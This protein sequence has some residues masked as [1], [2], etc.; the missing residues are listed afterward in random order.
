MHVTITG[1]GGFI[2]RRL[3]RQLLERGTLV[4]STGAHKPIEKIVACDLSLAALDA[5]PRVERVEADTSDPAVI[6]RIVTEKTRAVFHLAAV[7]SV[8]AEEDFEFGMRVNLEATRALLEA[9]RHIARGAHFLFASSAAVYGGELPAVVEDGIAL[10]PQ[11]SYGTQK[12]ICEMLIGDYSRRGFID[13]RALRLPTV[14]VRPGKPNKAA[15]TFASSIIRDPLE[16]R[17][18]ICPVAPETTMCLISPRKVVEAFIHAQSIP[19]AD[20]GWT[21]AV[22]LPGF[23]L[24][25][26]EMLA[27]LEQI[28][29]PN[30]ARRVRFE[31]DARIEKIVYGWPA[32]FK[33]AK[34]AR[35]GFTADNSM[36]DVIRAFIADDLN[37]EFIA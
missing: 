28:A 35:L 10:A 30:V 1:A 19:A 25:V 32:A 26:R 31:R 11:T 22:Q 7:V 13:G 18:V 4:D 20:W 2:G 6:S 21:R 27:A 29:G 8:G 15:S 16:G 5:D 3:V 34:A 12:A 17:Q 36:Q 37:G 23:T 24:T 9:C 14:V 33:S